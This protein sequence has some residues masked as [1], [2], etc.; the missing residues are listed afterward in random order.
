MSGYNF[1]PLILSLSK[2]MS[3]RRRAAPTVISSVAEKSRTAA[4]DSLQSYNATPC[5]QGEVVAA[6]Q[7]VL[8]SSTPLRS[9]QKDGRPHP[10]CACSITL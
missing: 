8:D 7:E 5:L 9:A 6:W 3:G 2:D 10:A 1:R 4:E